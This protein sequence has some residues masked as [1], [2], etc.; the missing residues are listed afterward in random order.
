MA[1]VLA[2]SNYLVRFPLGEWLTWAAF[3]YPLAFL[4]CDFVNRAAGAACARR[5]VAA[6]F[7]VGVPLSFVFGLGG[8]DAVIALRIAAASGAAFAAAQM[9][10]IA[11]FNRLRHAAWWLPPLASS[12]PAV[13]ADTFLFF[14]LA[15]AGTEVP[16]QVLATGDLAVKIGMALLLLP[17]YR[18]LTWRLANPGVVHP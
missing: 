3:T 4:V 11:I 14:A 17:P 18:L 15:F 1:L 7:I 12:L 10:D 6:G 2:M 13:S 16:W 8:G 9:L 5:V